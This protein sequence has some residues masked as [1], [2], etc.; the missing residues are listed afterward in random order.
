MRE[1]VNKDGSTG[2]FTE[3]FRAKYSDNPRES[4]EAESAMDF[5]TGEFVTQLPS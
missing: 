1:L 2:D 4:P 5:G 3:D